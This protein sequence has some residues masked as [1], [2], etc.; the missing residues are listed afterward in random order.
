[1]SWRAA[2]VAWPCRGMDKGCNAAMCVEDECKPSFR[3]WRDASYAMRQSRGD[4]QR[5][6]ALLDQ[7][8]EHFSADKAV[9]VWIHWSLTSINPQ[10]LSWWII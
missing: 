10:F 3:V 2:Q 6:L 1:M 9:G 4:T 7:V 8:D 5:G